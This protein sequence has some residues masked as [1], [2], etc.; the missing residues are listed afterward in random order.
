MKRIVL[1]TVIMLN[2]MLYGGGNYM[3][4]PE[5][6][7]SVGI[8]S[9]P[10]QFYG[11]LGLIA[12]STY[13]HKLNWFS[14]KLGQDRIGGVLALL[15]YQFAPNL[16]VEGRAS[17]VFISPHFSK[18]TNISLFLKPSYNVTDKIALYGL[19]GFG[20]SKI[21]GYGGHGNI[22][23]NISPQ[24]GLGAS[25]KVK[26]NIDIFADYT[27]LLH[28]KTAIT[29]MPDGSTKVSHEAVTVG[30]IYHF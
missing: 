15:G 12:T 19:L 30:A 4:S 16:A 11:G 18:S 2:S 10:S 25:Y 7:P 26:Q 3:P 21:D 23:K 13:G 14:Q 22:A 17:Y 20:W 8:S 24:I 29:A 9:T 5:P 1:S 27:W 6:I 28:N